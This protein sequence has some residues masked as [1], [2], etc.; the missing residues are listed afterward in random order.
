MS[1]PTAVADLVRSASATIHGLVEIMFTVLL[2]RLALEW[3]AVLSA[4]QAAPAGAFAVLPI[5]TRQV[6]GPDSR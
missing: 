3:I 5:R 1:L 4:T 2:Q 6:S